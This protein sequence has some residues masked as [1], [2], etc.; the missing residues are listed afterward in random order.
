M[1]LLRSDV[2][3]RYRSDDQQR[4]LEQRGDGRRRS[5]REEMVEVRWWRK[6]VEV[7]MEDLIYP[8][9]GEAVAAGSSSDCS[10]KLR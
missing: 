7:E 8:V 4:K 6:V 3:E 2:D 9:G 1:K 5:S 10:W